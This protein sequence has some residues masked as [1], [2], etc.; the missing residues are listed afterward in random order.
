MVVLPNRVEQ[1]GAPW[2]MLFKDKLP[3]QAVVPLVKTLMV[4]I[5][6]IFE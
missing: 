3:V 6:Q 2:S 1:P 4:I 5:F